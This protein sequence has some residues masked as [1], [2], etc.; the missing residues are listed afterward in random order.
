MHAS[1]RDRIK[2]PGRKDENVSRPRDDMD[3][4]AGLARLARFHPKSS[5]VERMPTIM[6]DSFLPDMGRMTR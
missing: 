3:E 4:T 6:D 2:H 1:A 5:A